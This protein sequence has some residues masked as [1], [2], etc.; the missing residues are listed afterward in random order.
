MI[1]NSALSEI[2]LLKGSSCPH[3]DEHCQYCLC[4]YM[5][6]LEEGLFYSECLLAVLMLTSVCVSAHDDEYHLH[7]EN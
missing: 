1:S 3:A 4:I 7:E 5:F 6:V 2:T